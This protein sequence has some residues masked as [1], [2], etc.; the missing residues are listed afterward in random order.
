MRLA[1]Q[2]LFPGRWNGYVA[3]LG[4]SLKRMHAGAATTSLM[5]RGLVGL[6]AASAKAR[7]KGIPR[8]WGI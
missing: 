5:T 8:I 2:G 3:L 7:C 6:S 4:A 1:Q